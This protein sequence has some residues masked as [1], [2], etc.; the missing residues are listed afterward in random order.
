MISDLI[1]LGRTSPPF[2]F[3]K[4]SYKFHK[5][6]TAQTLNWT[7]SRRRC[8]DSGSDLVSIES[9]KEW[10]FLRD[11]IQRM[12]TTEYYIGLRKDSKSGEWRWI[13]DNSKVNAT[14]GKFPWAKGEPSGDGNCALM[15]KDYRKD[16][17]L[18]NDFLCKEQKMH[19]GYICESRSS[20]TDEEGTSYKLLH[21]LLRL[22]FNSAI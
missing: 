17:G 18:F 15:Y 14:R 20:S 21:F 8:K 2:V 22:F 12:K 13:S 6:S 5:I 3:G 9:K 1:P 4:S 11:T 7:E 19:R 10:R 16:N